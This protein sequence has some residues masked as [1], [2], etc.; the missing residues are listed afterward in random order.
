MFIECCKL[1]DMR[2]IPNTLAYFATGVSYAHKMFMKLAPVANVI[3]LFT[4]I[5]YDFS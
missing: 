4:A 2:C 3:K 1:H 5:S